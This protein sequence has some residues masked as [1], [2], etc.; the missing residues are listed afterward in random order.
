MGV[1]RCQWQLDL[2]T[3]NVFAVF[4]VK[5]FG[6]YFKF[7]LL[8]WIEWEVLWIDSMGRKLLHCLSIK[9][10]CESPWCS[11]WQ[12]HGQ[13]Q[14]SQNSVVGFFLCST[15]LSTWHNL[16]YYIIF[17]AS[18]SSNLSNQYFLK[19][20]RHY[21]QSFF[22]LQGVL[23]EK[24]CS[25]SRSVLRRQVKGFAPGRYVFCA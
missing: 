13:F 5:S 1:I 14:G 7:Q 21:K 12:P 15:V 11:L 18:W 3:I 10:R 2:N 19:G 25:S 17:V 6:Y 9:L 24:E 16:L 22:Q 4:H 23:H 8:Q 20:L